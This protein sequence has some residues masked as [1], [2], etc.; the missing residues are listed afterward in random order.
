MTVEDLFEVA[1]DAIETADHVDISYDP[2]LGYP[3]TVS[4]DQILEAVDD[5]F[6]W[7]IESF[8]AAG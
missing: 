1:Q 3:T 5:E 6:T 4:V 8:T 2:D 7:T